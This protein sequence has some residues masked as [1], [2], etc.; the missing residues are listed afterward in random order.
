MTCEMHLS[1][2]RKCVETIL[3]FRIPAYLKETVLCTTIKTSSDLS[4]WNKTWNLFRHS[5]YDSER[6]DILLAVG[7]AKN[8][9]LLKK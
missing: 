5:N 7:C 1:D 4:A 6:R 3:F 2:T 9:T 8:Q